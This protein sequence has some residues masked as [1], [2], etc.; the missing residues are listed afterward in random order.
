MGNPSDAKGIGSY[1]I[2]PRWYLGLPVATAL[3]GTETVPAVQAGK[4]VQVPLSLLEPALSSAYTN[5]SP[6]SLP[7]FRLAL[8]QVRTGAGNAQIAL[9]GDSTSAGLGAPGGNGYT[10]AHALAYPAWLQQL[11]NAY[12]VPAQADSFWGDNGFATVAGATVPVVDPR[13]VLGAGWGPT[14]VPSVGGSSFFN[15]TTTNPIAFTPVNA[16]DTIVVTYVQNTALGTL[17][18]DIGGAALSTFSTAGVGAFVRKTISTGAAPAT[19]TVNVRIS[20]TPASTFVIGVETL[21]STKPTVSVWNNG[22]CGATALSLSSTSSPW[23]W[24]PGLVSMAPS[25]VICGIGINDSREITVAAYIAAYQQFITAVTAVSDMIMLIEVP[26]E[27]T[28]IPEAT[29]EQFVTAQYALAAANNL[30]V[31][32]LRKRFVSW[33]AAN[34][35]GYMWDPLHCLAVGYSDVASAVFNAPGLF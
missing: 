9:T 27:T 24:Q 31:I 35:L 21:N 33:A 10:G 3:T 20:G 32:D 8:A 5:F 13:I 25:L 7:R 12:A 22:D 29:Q 14:G 16:F 6:N 11:L 15:N 23:S 1:H 26:S 30:P 18:V 28:I 4:D 2:T 19:G 17:A 34:A